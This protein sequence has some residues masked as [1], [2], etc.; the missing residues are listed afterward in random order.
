MDV[1]GGILFSNHHKNLNHLQKD[2]TD[3]VPVIITMGGNI[4]GGDTMFYYGVKT[5]DLGSRFHVLEHLHGRMMFGP[6]EEKIHEGTLWI[7]HRSVIY[8]IL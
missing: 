2:S 3:L 5:S 4:S 1:I 8:F 6:F 7:G